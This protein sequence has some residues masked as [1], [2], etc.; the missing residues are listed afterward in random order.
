MRFAEFAVRWIKFSFG[1]ALI[2]CGLV[3]LGHMCG[4]SRQD[5][6]PSLSPAMKRK[7]VEFMLG[8]AA[9]TNEGLRSLNL[10]QH[11]SPGPITPKPEEF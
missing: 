10:G 4:C 2:L 7:Q 9:H 1:A 5:E 8:Q 11:A 6:G 3:V